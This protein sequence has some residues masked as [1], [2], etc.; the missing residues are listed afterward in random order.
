MPERRTVSPRAAVRAEMIE[1]IKDSAREHLAAEGP[2]LSLR[3]VARDLGMVSSAVYR[4]FA[5]RDDLLTALIIDGYDAMGEAVE[6]AE[7]AVARRDLQGRWIALGR[8]CRQWSLERP[9]EYA[10]LYGSPI[11]GYA[12]PQDTI[13]SAQRPILVAAAIMR[14]GVDSGRLATPADRLPKAVRADIA[15]VAGYPGVGGIPPT[16]L[17]RLMTVW[18]QLFGTL[19]FELF[20]RYTNGVNDLDAYFEHQLRVMARYLGIV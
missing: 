19:S 10:L 13:A 2:D 5:S 7:G 12:A 8:A 1:Q 20:G 3:A 17:A 9:H 11:P 16:L 6:L 4:Y 14:D 18:A 15:T